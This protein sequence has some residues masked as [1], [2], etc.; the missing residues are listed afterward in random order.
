VQ[1]GQ[2][3]AATGSSFCGGTSHYYLLS[4][5]TGAFIVHGAAHSLFSRADVTVELLN[6]SGVRFP[7]SQTFE[8]VF[9]SAQGSGYTNYDSQA[10]LSLGSTP[11]DVIVRITQRATLSTSAFPSGSNG[12][13]ASPFYV[14]T[15]SR[16]VT[17]GNAIYEMNARC[18]AQDTFSDYAQAGDPGAMPGRSA[19]SNNKSSGGCG[20]IT[21][22]GDDEG[23]FNGPGAALRLGNFLMLALML[24]A[25]RRFM[26]KDYL[27]I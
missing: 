26:G 3:P 20:M 7:G 25:A 13:D 2:L 16:G 23:P 24:A 21:Y 18:E 4:G 11:T 9:I 8:N 15:V 14:L 12:V 19:P 10:S 22:G 1:N 17:A 5:M 6:T 27:R